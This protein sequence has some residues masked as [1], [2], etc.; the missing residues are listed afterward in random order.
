MLV[1]PKRVELVAYSQLPHLITPV[2]NDPKLANEALKW[3][4]TEMDRRYQL[5]PMARAKDIESYNQ[6]IVTQKLPKMPYIVIVIDEFADLMITCGNDVVDSVQRITQMGRACGIHLI[7]ATQ[8]PSTNVIPGTIKVNIPT[9]IAFKVTQGIDSMTILDQYGAEEL[10]GQGD[11]LFSEVDAP[12][13][14]QGPY[15]TDDE[16]LRVTDFISDNYRPDYIFTH[17]Q[18]VEKTKKEY[19]ASNDEDMELV[20]AVAE[21]VLERGT[22]SINNIQQQF[23]LGF[24]RAQKIVNILEERG[25]VS[26]KKGTTGREILITIDQL[27]EVLGDN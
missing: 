1:D 15:I 11:M 3:A 6:R 12:V 10:L 9:R 7:V 24:N 19:G 14:L 8:R 23:S 5:F 21:N 2:I 22:C 27:D 13:R 16:I 20:R 4:C 25:I 18:L 17:D 26:E